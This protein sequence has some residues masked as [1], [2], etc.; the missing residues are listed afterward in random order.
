V[1]TPLLC[2]AEHSQLVVVD[3]QI[4]LLAAMSEP[5]R[6]AMVKNTE[7]L[8]QAAEVLDIPVLYTE[9]YPK[10][11]GPT[12]PAIAERMPA[13]AR[14][15]EKTGFSCCAADGFSKTLKATGRE[16]VI[17]V[18]QETHVCV[19]QTALELMAEG[20]RV[21]VVED[22]VCSRSTVHKQ[23]A[24]ARMRE[25]GGVVTNIESVVF[26]WLRDA[27]HPQFKALSKLIREIPEP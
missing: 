11:L 20:Y 6:A 17:L 15:L 4:R 14:G 5:E 26:E 12:V 13:L 2:S 8:L 18:G 24:L 10:G 3:L 7:I 9:Q 25:A 22:A 19:L 23:N 16:Q 21:F 1:S 27:A